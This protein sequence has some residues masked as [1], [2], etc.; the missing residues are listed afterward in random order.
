MTGRWLRAWSIAS[1]CT[2]RRLASVLGSRLSASVRIA[3]A[4][5]G[6]RGVRETRSP[7]SDLRSG[8]SLPIAPDRW[9]GVGNLRVGPSHVR[10]ARV[11]LTPGSQSHRRTGS[12]RTPATHADDHSSALYGPPSYHHC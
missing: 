2:A 3:D 12:E 6:A 11:H 10:P 5:C 1:P 8:S 4:T 9:S 7:R